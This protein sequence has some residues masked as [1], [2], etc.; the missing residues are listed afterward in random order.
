[1]GEAIRLAD[2]ITCALLFK[3]T[4]ILNFCN[5]FVNCNP[6]EFLLKQL[7]YPPSFSLSDSELTRLHL[8]DHSLVENSGSQSSC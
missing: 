6:L 5:L 3:K 2:L 4:I 1:M 7:D 8:F